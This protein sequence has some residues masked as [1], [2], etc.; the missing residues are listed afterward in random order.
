MFAPVINTV[1]IIDT[2][3]K[4]FICCITGVHYKGQLCSENP[5]S[6]QWRL[7]KLY[8]EDKEKTCS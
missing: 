8:R 5:F 3:N 7:T 6:Q 2:R 1:M 4:G